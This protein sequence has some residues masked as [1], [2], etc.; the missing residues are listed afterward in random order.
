LGEGAVDLSLAFGFV[1]EDAVHVLVDDPG[2]E[3]SPVDDL[4]G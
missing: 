3:A 1:A 2:G 4:L